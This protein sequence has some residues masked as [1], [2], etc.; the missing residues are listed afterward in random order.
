M[1]LAC[2]LW[3]SSPGPVP[4]SVRR[5]MHPGRVVKRAITPKPIKQMRR[6]MH[7]IDNAVYGMQR[8]LSTKRSHRR[9]SPRLSPRRLLRKPP[10]FR[11]CSASAGEPTATGMLG[12]GRNRAFAT[13]GRGRVRTYRPG[14]RPSWASRASSDIATNDS[15]LGVEVFTLPND[16]GHLQPR[17]AGA[18]LGGGRSDGRSPAGRRY[19]NRS[20][21]DACD[22]GRTATTCNQRCNHEQP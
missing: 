11:G 4:R 7:P 18:G 17:Y 2:W 20:G 12:A 15:Q 3:G 10:N 13:G 9:K 5:A 16:D 6:A 21:T 19:A 1:V 22:R 14:R 8:S